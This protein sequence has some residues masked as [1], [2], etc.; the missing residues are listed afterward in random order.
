MNDF[1]AMFFWYLREKRLKLNSLRV[2]DNGNVGIGCGRPFVVIDIASERRTGG[3]VGG[4]GH[5]FCT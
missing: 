2:S 5:L 3:S 1:T 4:S